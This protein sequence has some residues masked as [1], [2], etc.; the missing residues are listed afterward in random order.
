M[1]SPTSQ[2]MNTFVTG[3]LM[4]EEAQPSS[5]LIWLNGAPIY[6]WN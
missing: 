1:R 4:L 3:V 5:L 6:C 2:G